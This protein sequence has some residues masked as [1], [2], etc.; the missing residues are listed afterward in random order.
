MQSQSA[1]SRFS[2]D[3]WVVVFGLDPVHC[4]SDSREQNW[5]ELETDNVVYESP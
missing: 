3:E 1:Q 5:N 4:D 2:E